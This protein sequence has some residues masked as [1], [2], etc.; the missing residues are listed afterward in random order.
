MLRRGRHLRHLHPSGAPL[1]PPPL[2]RRRVARQL[3][4]GD[5]LVLGQEWV[6]V[7]H[8][9]GQDVVR[10]AWVSFEGVEGTTALAGGDEVVVAL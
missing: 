7:V 2:V 1:P 6:T 9:D 5:L 8:V 4:E 10:V 3:E